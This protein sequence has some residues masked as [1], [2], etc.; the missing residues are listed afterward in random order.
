MTANRSVFL[1]HQTE[2]SVSAG[3]TEA[4]GQEYHR[5]KTGRRTAV[6]RS[7]SL[8][9][10]RYSAVRIY[11]KVPLVSRQRCADREAGVA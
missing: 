3:R 11:E 4:G 8:P 1:K 7:K 10:Q 6:L 5:S 2:S 9:C